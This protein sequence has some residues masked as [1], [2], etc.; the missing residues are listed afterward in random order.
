MKSK[1][2]IKTQKQN[3]T[4]SII[5]APTKDLCNQ[6]SQA[7]NSILY[8]CRDLVTCCSLADDNQS[9]IPYRLQNIP[10]I[11]VS[12]P[13]K[14]VHQVRTN[15]LDL[16]EIHSIAIDEADL[17]LSFGYNEDVTFITSQLPK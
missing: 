12:T 8:Y 17:I 1:E 2:S 9:L 16:S 7:I 14:I 4:S 13:A 5:L 6:I 15:N 10:D 11:I 3:S